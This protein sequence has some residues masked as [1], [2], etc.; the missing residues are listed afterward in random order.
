MKTHELPTPSRQAIEGQRQRAA[1]RQE[2][3][4]PTIPAARP[5]LDPTQQ[6]YVPHPDHVPADPSK[7]L[8]PAWGQNATIDAA[9][10]PMLPGDQR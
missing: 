2:A 8:R 3:N 1:N 5:P 7:K 4:E 10:A 9:T 6:H